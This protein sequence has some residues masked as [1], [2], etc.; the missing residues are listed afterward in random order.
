M[1]T[2]TLEVTDA[3]TTLEVDGRNIIEYTLHQGHRTA[4]RI[5]Q[6]PP[7]E[8][9]EKNREERIAAAKRWIE[10]ASSLKLTDTPQQLRDSY[11]EHLAK[12]YLDPA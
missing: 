4:E 7:R 1:S 2:M 12:K 8:E 10:A 3:I 11:A 6:A 5:R 9:V